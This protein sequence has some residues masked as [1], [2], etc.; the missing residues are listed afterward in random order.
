MKKLITGAATLTLLLACLPAFCAA[1]PANP[2]YDQEK[3]A[4]GLLYKGK[5]V[6]LKIGT[7]KVDV[8]VK[9]TEYLLVSI[10]P[11]SGDLKSIDFKNNK[12]NND[13][14]IVV[15]HEYFFEDNPG[16]NEDQ[17]LLIFEVKRPSSNPVE[18]TLITKNPTT[19]SE[20][21]YTLNVTVI[22]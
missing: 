18:I 11:K 7:K 4:Y 2:T 10:P 17:Q 19:K 14:D 8:D 12:Y 5:F 15:A 16:V 6:D 9:L 20:K 1:K 13:N 22:E 21:T 3:I